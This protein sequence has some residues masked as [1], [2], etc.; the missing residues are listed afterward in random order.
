MCGPRLREPVNNKR[1]QCLGDIWMGVA[2]RGEEIMIVATKLAG[3]QEEGFAPSDACYI[4]VSLY[5][6]AF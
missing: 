4:R 1:S 2:A 5:I 3:L 6:R